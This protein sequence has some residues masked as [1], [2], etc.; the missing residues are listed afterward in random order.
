MFLIRI[1]EEL[2]CPDFITN[3]VLSAT[4]AGSQILPDVCIVHSIISDCDRSMALFD[5][6]DSFHEL[7]QN[8]EEDYV[9]D[10]WRAMPKSYWETGSVSRKKVKSSTD[11]EKSSESCRSGKGNAKNQNYEQRSHDAVDPAIK[12]RFA[13]AVCELESSGL[14]KLVSGGTEINRLV[15]AWDMNE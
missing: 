10:Q 9:D 2:R 12:C 14:I 11:G 15:F 8:D 1:L 4:T 13:A 3:P 7:I 6:F 5:C